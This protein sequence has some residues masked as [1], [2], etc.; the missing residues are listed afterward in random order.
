L[1][2]N[3]AFGL[4]SISLLSLLLFG[5]ELFEDDEDCICTSLT[6]VF[7]AFIKFDALDDIFFN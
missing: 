7:V 2:S 3:Q 4:F 5:D 6:I 1:I